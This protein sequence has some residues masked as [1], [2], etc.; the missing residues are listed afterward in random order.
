MNWGTNEKGTN[1]MGD[2]WVGGTNEMGDQWNEWCMGANWGTNEMGDQWDGEP[3]RW[4][5]NE[6]GDQWCAPVRIPESVA[7]RAS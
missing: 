1:E 4:G 2:Q 6:M 3:M 5:T 7:P